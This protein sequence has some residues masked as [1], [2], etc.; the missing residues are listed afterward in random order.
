MRGGKK[1]LGKCFTLPFKLGLC[2]SLRLVVKHG[3]VF[4][5]PPF[6]HVLMNQQR[7]LDRTASPAEEMPL[8][9]TLKGKLNAVFPSFASSVSHVLWRILAPT[10]G[11]KPHSCCVAHK[12]LMPR[13]A[14]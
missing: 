14:L 8:D 5:T 11:R 10:D 7:F 12:A 1:T 6:C 2:V 3:A 13:G 4:K 9:N